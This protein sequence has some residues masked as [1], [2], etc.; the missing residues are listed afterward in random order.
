MEHEL[1]RFE[2]RVPAPSANETKAL[3]AVV[4]RCYD[5]AEHPE[6]LRD[7]LAALAEI[8][9]AGSALLLVRDGGEQRLLAASHGATR[10][11]TA[12]RRLPL[13][14]DTPR[15]VPLGGGFELV[16]DRVDDAGGALAT[17]GSLAPHLARALRLGERLGARPAAL[18]LRTADL[19]RLSLGVVLLGADGGAVAINR[20][21]RGVLAAAAA[22]ELD[23]RHLAPRAPVPNAL[24]D[25]LVERI[26]SPPE[27]G[28]RFVGGR[29][30][31]TDET[32]GEIDLLL[33]RFDTRC[34]GAI[35]H[36][37]AL[38][39]AQRATTSPEARFQEMFGLDER[40]AAL[41][42]ELVVGRASGDAEDAESARAAIAAL[43]AKLGTTRQ[44]DLVRLLLRPPGVVF[45]TAERARVV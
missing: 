10:L 43:Y 17:L 19:D 13:R 24:V 37:V 21:A 22:L 38:V 12:D 40:Q 36:G 3:L 29:V 8:A 1:L 33:T 28:R 7:A 42:V 34:E 27:A 31:L 16:L 41:A 18:D 6:R 26:V 11:A 15:T 2:H 44:A 30:R 20:A 4:E 9:G 45:E 32:W 23:A 39:T 14:S 25:S 35:V 5:A